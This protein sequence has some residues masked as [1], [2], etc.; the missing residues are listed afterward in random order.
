MRWVEF[1]TYYDLQ[2]KYNH[3]KANVVAD[4]LSRNTQMATIVMSIWNL[5]AQLVDWHP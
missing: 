4:V 5:V 1:L 3:G 2:M